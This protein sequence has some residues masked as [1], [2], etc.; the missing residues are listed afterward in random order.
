[1]YF[2]KGAHYYALRHEHA[3]N[4]YAPWFDDSHA[5]C[6]SVGPA[7]VRRANEQGG[8]RTL[9]CARRNDHANGGRAGAWLIAGT[10]GV[11]GLAGSLEYP[12]S[13]FTFGRGGTG[14]LARHSEIPQSRAGYERQEIGGH[15]R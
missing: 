7:P 15:R 2:G 6:L 14:L 5:D 4:A 8:P 11:Q 13:R 10:A 12:R 9:A 3:P 1:M